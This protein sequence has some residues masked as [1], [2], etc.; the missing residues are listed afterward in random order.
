MNIGGIGQSWGIIGASPAA[1]GGG[2]AAD[3]SAA[4]KAEFLEWARMSPG[5]RL[6]ATLLASMGLDEDQLAAM[7]PDKR[8]GVET[9]LRELIEEK[10][11]AGD[12]RPGQLVDKSV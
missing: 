6:R 9:K 11:R 10:V 1:G 4:V 3:K 5:E 8:M 7:P 2:A 12:E